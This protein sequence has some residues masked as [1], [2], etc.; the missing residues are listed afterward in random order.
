MKDIEQFLRE[1][2][3][4]TPDE[5]QFLIETN[6]RMDSVEGIKKTVDGEY[7]RWR[8]AL[9]IALALGLVLG[10]LLTLLAVFW[11]VQT[12]N[13]SLSKTVEALKGGKE[14]LMGFVACC[15]IGLGIMSMTK[16][17]EVF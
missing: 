2:V 13:S 4:E 12:D 17:R 6:A 3:P 9:V 5:G 1:N 15:A 7:R 10:C 14:I 16:K 8:K 11:P